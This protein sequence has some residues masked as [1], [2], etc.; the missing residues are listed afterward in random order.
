MSRTV[1]AIRT[2]AL[3]ATTLAA[4]VATPE[5]SAIATQTPTVS[6]PA[7]VHCRDRFVDIHDPTLT[8]FADTTVGLLPDNGLVIMGSFRE[9]VA[10]RIHVFEW[11]A[12]GWAEVAQ[13]P[14]IAFQQES[15]IGDKSGHHFWNGQGWVPGNGHTTF[16]PPRA[17]YYGFT[18]DYYWFPTTYSPGASLSA[19]LD[20]PGMFFG[21]DPSGSTSCRYA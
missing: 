21:A 1:R 5:A 16:T 3:L 8:T 15:R 7:F 6:T 11:T 19:S 18:A 10:Y 20:Q 2:A 12:G 13:G 9:W 17:G 4:V 14:W